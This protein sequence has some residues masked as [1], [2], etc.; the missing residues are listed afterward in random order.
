MKEAAGPNADYTGSAVPFW[1]DP[2]KRAIIF[3]V[4]VLL[5]VFGI[6]YVLFTNTQANL[7]RQSIATGFGS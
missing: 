7:R 6:A 2:N 3:Q 4:V 5:L 1:R